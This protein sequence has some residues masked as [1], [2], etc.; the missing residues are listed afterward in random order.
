MKSLNTFCPNM[1]CGH[2]VGKVGIKIFALLFLFAFSFCKETEPPEIL[3]EHPFTISP[4]T[5]SKGD[6]VTIKGQNF[7]KRS[8]FVTVTF[9]DNLAVIQSLND[10]IIEAI[11]PKDAGTGLVKVTVQ[12]TEMIGPE[13]TYIVNLPEI[14]SVSIDAGT[15]GDLMV[16][17]GVNFGDNEKLISVTINGDEAT[18]RKSSDLKL[19]VI[20]PNASGIGLVRVTVDGTEVEGPSFSYGTPHPADVF[21]E[22]VNLGEGA[23][24]AIA[25]DYDNRIVHLV[26]ALGSNLYYRQGDL[27]GNFGAP[28]EVFRKVDQN[29]AIRDQPAIVLDDNN[30]PHVSIVEGGVFIGKSIYYINR[31]GGTWSSALKVFDIDGEGLQMGFNSFMAV[32]GNTVFMASFIIGGTEGNPTPKNAYVR[33]DDINTTPVVSKKVFTTNFAVAYPYLKSNGELWVF[34]GGGAWAGRWVLQQVDKTTMQP[35]GDEVLFLGG[36]GAEQVRWLFDDKGEIHASSATWKSNNPKMEGWYQTLSRKNAGL[37]PIN[38]KT[39]NIHANGGAQPVR[40]LVAPDRVYVAYWNG[41]NDDDKFG[42]DGENPYGCT[43]ENQIN[44]MRVENGEK[45][46]ERR[47][48]TSRTAGIH[49]TSYR[50]GPAAAAHPDGGM[51]VIF[52]ECGKENK[53]RNYYTFPMQLYFTHIGKVD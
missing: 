6:I 40:D 39:T 12:S 15:F 10:T 20:V 37:L 33:I 24:P 1:S 13:F 36:M 35:I 23:R 7:G 38:F 4:D 49:G 29:S 16:I 28:E 17:E 25:I 53:E 11:V 9:N 31:I 14:T 48:I 34:E 32:E 30:M 50:S 18:I 3:V 22:A 26:Y 51:I 46:N 27:E 45:A 42:K 47:R 52:P 8:S 41:V 2:W 44:F 43:V 19:N 21:T 5:G